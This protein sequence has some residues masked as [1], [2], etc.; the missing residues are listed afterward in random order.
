MITFGL[1]VFLLLITPGPGVLTLAGVGSAFGYKPGF[2]YLLGLLI[3][4]NLVAIAVVSGLAA[5]LLAAPI[6]RN[7]LLFL[8]VG[9]LC[10]LAY[11]IAF[12]GTKTA[13]AGAQKEPGISGGVMLQAI[14]PK[15]YVVNTSLFTGFAIWPDSFT[16]EITYKFVAMN[17]IWISIHI[18]W[19][20]IGVTI[21]RLNLAPRTQFIINIAMALALL[22]VIF[23]ALWTQFYR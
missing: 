21:N 6:V 17:V 16:A 3:G 5:I 18:L 14:N 13:F 22:S 12:S 2:R 19:L 9:Y 10:F 8:S 7:I 20:A 23:L 15:A 4:Q 1:A 11:K